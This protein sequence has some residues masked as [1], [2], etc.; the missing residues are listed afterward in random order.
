MMLTLL[1]PRPSKHSVGIRGGTVTD[2]SE[3]SGGGRSMSG[4][5]AEKGGESGERR[6]RMD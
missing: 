1:F 2:P 3:M 5:V 6:E 4:G